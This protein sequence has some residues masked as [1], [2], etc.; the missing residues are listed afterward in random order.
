[1]NSRNSIKTKCL[2]LSENHGGNPKSSAL[3]SAPKYRCLVHFMYIYSVYINIY[4][5]MCVYIYMYIYIYTYTHIHIHSHTNR[6]FMVKSW[7]K[8]ISK[9]IKIYQISI[10]II[11]FFMVKSHDTS[12]FSATVALAQR[13][14]GR[15]PPHRCSCRALKA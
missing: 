9:H 5:Y 15:G 1:M 7:F 11:T 4:I 6:H 2:S 13:P 12:H 14:G 8:S 10:K 3:S